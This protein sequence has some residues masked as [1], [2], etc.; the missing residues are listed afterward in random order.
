MD[1]TT[2]LKVAPV[3]SQ[4]A[5]SSLLTE[6]IEVGRLYIQPGC[7][8]GKLI[9]CRIRY[10]DGSLKE[11]KLIIKTRNIDGL[12]SCVIAGFYASP[13]VVEPVR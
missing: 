5:D 8:I 2:T 1:E 3:S 10:K 12:P 4:M 11:W 6:L 13:V 9:P 7:G